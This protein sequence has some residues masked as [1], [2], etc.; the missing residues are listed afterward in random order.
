ME[1]QKSVS[2]TMRYLTAQV[3]GKRKD[4]GKTVEVPLKNQQVLEKDVIVVLRNEVRNWK[5]R[6]P[7]ASGG[8]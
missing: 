6:D 8:K 5:V 1:K 4:C 2:L 7:S 3:Y